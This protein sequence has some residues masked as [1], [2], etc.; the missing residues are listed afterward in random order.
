M[1]GL[2]FTNSGAFVNAVNT[3]KIKRPKKKSTD[4]ISG[5]PINQ[6]APTVPGITITKISI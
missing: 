2:F 4:P 6:L 1:N 3:I 5:T